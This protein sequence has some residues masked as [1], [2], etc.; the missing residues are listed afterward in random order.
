M[1]V[2][3]WHAISAL[4]LI[5]EHVED[6]LA[7]SE[8]QLATLG[9]ARGKPYVL[10]DAIVGRAKRLFTEQREF[11]AIYAEQVRRWQRLDLDAATAARVAALA[12]TVERLREVTGEVLALVEE[13]AKGT[14]DKIMAMSDL[15]LGMRSLAGEF[16]IR[17]P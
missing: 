2:P 7:G 1:P 13:L 12:G 11:V 8:E 6:S 9:E 14:I 16:P 5:A 17:E 3:R 15:E 10:N 4:P